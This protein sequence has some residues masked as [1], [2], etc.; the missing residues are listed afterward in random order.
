MSG[1]DRQRRAARLLPVG[2]AVLAACDPGAEDFQPAT[3][4]QF[5]YDSGAQGN[6]YF[7]ETM[8]SGAALFDA[9]ADGALDVYWVQGG[10]IP[11]SSDGRARPTNQLFLG[12]GKGA[13]R[14]ATGSAGDAAHAGYGMGVC[15]ADV[16]GDGAAD[17]FLTNV[18]P[19]CLLLGDPQQPGS[20]IEA[21]PP[22]L[23]DPR[24]NT[25]CAFGDIN[26]DGHLDLG[27]IGYVAWS[28]AT[29]P[30]C[31]G[32]SVLDYCSVELF[33]GLTDRLWIGDGRGGFEEVTDAWGFGEVAA[34]GLGL[35]FVDVDLDGFIDAYVANDTESNRL[36]LNSDGQTFEDHTAA[37]GAGASAD[38]AH[39]AGMGV[40][41]GDINLD[42]LPDLVVTNFA[43]EPNSVYQNR[44]QGWFRERSRALGVAAPS[45]SRLAFG[46]NL[47]D[48][49]GDGL[50]DLFTACGHVSRHVDATGTTF[51]WK[52]PDQLLLATGSG[53]FD[54]HALGSLLAV[55]RVGR[56]SAVGDL[57]GDGALDL[58]VSNSD[59]AGVVALNRLR[60]VGSGSLSV[61]LSTDRGSNSEAIG[62]RVTLV[63]DDGAELHRWR[64]SGT[65]YLSQDDPRAHFAIPAGRSANELRVAWPDGT[66]S[67]HPVEPE[68]G[69]ARVA[70]P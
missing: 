29:Q 9:N 14:D 28:A 11:G 53:P 40:A 51:T 33:D 22:K 70:Q 17:L 19:D 31:A 54:Q 27:V 13:L 4:P 23:A 52:Q 10:P 24:W 18:G 69:V 60:P 67:T 56:G 7:P 61:E 38:G 68:A 64:R 41:V 47:A 50:E 15:V 34:R 43:A 37:S 25:A 5:T 39:E 42:G 2:L 1:S 48:F 57:D 65:G 45:L 30:D 62:A 59:G 32:S 12:D 46:V 21:T 66:S 26:R 20:F 16:N 36:Y 3:G 49:D 6:Y 58:V 44:G 55:P 35:A 63:L 8:G